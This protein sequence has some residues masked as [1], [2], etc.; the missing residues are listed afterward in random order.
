VGRDT[1]EVAYQQRKGA[2]C[3]ITLA[4]LLSMR[5]ESLIETALDKTM[6]SPAVDR[7]RVDFLQDEID[8]RETMLDLMECDA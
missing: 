5:D 6:S 8:E 2:R 3:M 1:S 7:M 4:D